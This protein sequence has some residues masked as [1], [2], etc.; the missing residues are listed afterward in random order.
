[1]LSFCHGA[2]L[3]ISCYQLPICYQLLSLLSFSVLLSLG[4]RRR[5]RVLEAISTHIDSEGQ[6]DYGAAADDP[7]IGQAYVEEL[8]Q[9]YATGADLQ[10]GR[11]RLTW[12]RQKS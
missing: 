12:K 9:A 2:P 10:A 7:E 3:V 6:L 11:V 8:A 5:S 1:V 4:R